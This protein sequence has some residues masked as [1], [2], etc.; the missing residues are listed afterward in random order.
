MATA[1]PIGAGGSPGGGDGSRGG[2][3]RAN[4][5]HWDRDSDRYQ[6]GHGDWIAANPDT[7]GAWAVP[8]ADVRVLPDVAG[9]DV[10]EFGCGGAQWSI[11]L[12]R[13]GARV[14]GLDLSGRQLAHAGR[15][16]TAAGVQVRLVHGSGERLPLASA[17]FDVVLSDHGAMSW[18][19]PAR[20][21][22][23]VARVLRPGGVLV[24]ATGG[25]FLR[26]CWDARRGPWGAPG[27]RLR[28]AYFGL[29]PEPQGDG[30]VSFT[31]GY[32][33]WVRRF[34]AHRLAIEALVEPQ[35]PPGG[36]SP[37]Y[38]GATEWAQRW[39]AEMIWKV[40]REA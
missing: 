7:W 17:A 40:R 39:P 13:R 19:D 9:K 21:V 8:E 6:A 38:P 4:R 16:V 30:A 34:R 35:P 31:P 3:E 32:G 5:A 22:P 2:H 12:A 10:L 36:V 24:F 25:P 29:R 18:G 26:L 37:F 20:T 27:D 28:R 11:R 15:A 33:E 23:E 1:T 14:T